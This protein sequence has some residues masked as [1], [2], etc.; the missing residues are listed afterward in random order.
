MLF[1]DEPLVAQVDSENGKTAVSIPSYHK[2]TPSSSS[3][4][5]QPRCAPHYDYSAADDN[6]V[7]FIFYIIF[8]IIFF[9]LYI[10]LYTY[11]CFFKNIA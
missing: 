9:I 10:I 11:Y 5:E 6:E 1:I 7:F 2:L 3:N 8:F 4:T